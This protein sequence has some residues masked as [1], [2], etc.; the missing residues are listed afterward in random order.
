MYVSNKVR[1][2]PNTMVFWNG[3]LVP[4]EDYKDI[5]KK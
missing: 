4:L 1:L 3:V 2:I 5:D